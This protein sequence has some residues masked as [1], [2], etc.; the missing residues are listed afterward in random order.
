MFFGPE[1]RRYISGAGN[2]LVTVL[3]H[4]DYLIAKRARATYR[5]LLG[6]LR[7]VRRRQ[8]V[9]FAL[10]GEVDL[11]WRRRRQMVVVRDGD[12]WRTAAG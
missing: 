5:D 9:W 11:W 3:A 6:H 10:P 12:S 8:N 7:D 4:P 1:K 2:G